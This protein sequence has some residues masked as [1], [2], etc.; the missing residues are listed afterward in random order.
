MKNFI[1]IASYPKSGN[2]MIRL[3]LALYFFTE[4]GVLKNFDV[5]KNIISLN[6]YSILNKI[7]NPPKINSFK[8][9]P[10]LI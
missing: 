6:R 7:N 3:F 4:D 9:N 10:E 8:D 1:W 2:T 5:L